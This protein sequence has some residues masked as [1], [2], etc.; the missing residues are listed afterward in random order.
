MLE[1]SVAAEYRRE[2]LWGIVV[3]ERQREKCWREVLYRSIVAEFWEPNFIPAT[4][5]AL[6][7]YDNPK[8]GAKTVQSSTLLQ[9][10]LRHFSPA[11]FHIPLQHPSFQHYPTTLPPM[12][13][14]AKTLTPRHFSR[15]SYPSSQHPS[16]PYSNTTLFPFSPTLCS[17]LAG[18]PFSPKLKRNIS[19][20][21]NTSPSSF[22][23]YCTC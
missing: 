5:S 17:K 21:L 14:L 12:P 18:T 19:Y 1:I 9:T 16:L 15:T 8:T 22:C 7:G 3:V 2:V 23:Q 6:R 20:P 11:L 4:P 13:L 10:F